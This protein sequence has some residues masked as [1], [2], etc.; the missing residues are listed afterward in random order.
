MECDHVLVFMFCLNMFTDVWRVIVFGF[1][2][3]VFC[4]RLSSWWA[5]VNTSLSRMPGK[6]NIF[7]FLIM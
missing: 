3:E 6:L 2:E 7:N 4:P 5:L 1:L